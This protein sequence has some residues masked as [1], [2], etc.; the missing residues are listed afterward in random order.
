MIISL[1]GVRDSP[2]VFSIHISCR[3]SCIKDEYMPKNKQSFSLT[4]CLPAHI[5]MYGTHI[6][7]FEKGV[8]R[9]SH[10]YM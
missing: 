1:N 10:M 5:Y 6:K 7:C 9:E 4:R 2:V 8:N 3:G